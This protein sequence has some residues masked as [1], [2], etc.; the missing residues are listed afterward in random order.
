MIADQTGDGFD[1]PDRVTRLPTVEAEISVRE[2]GGVGRPDHVTHLTLVDPTLIAAIRSLHREHRGLQSAVTAMTLRIKADERWVAAARVRS[3]GG[4]LDGRKFP[5]PT[6]AD[7]L[8]IMA[9]RPRYYEARAGLEALRKSCQ[10]ELIAATRQLPVAP[11]VDTVQG[12]GLPSLAAVVGEAGD[13]GGY[14][15]PA[16]LWK[17]FSLHVIAGKAARRVRG[18]DSQQ[19]IGRRRAE[20]HIIGDN[21]VRKGGPYADLYRTRKA[22]ETAR[23]K[24]AGIRVLPAARIPVAKREQ[25]MSA[26][27]VHKRALRYIE[28]RLLLD[29][30]RAWRRPKQHTSPYDASASAETTVALSAS[31]PQLRG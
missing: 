7:R 19:F 17:R 8:A 15:N 3:E 18:D 27:Q 11:W 21:L 26:G 31:P 24:A 25:I 10:A 12:F 1:H 14:A 9:M 5:T 16:K 6:K 4:K 22:Y 13:L 2:G 23:L 30:W 20:A 28:K 29:L